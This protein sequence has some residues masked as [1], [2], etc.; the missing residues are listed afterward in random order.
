MILALSAFL[1]ATASS[2]D[3]F[4]VGLS[5]GLAKQQLSSRTNGII[6]VC[7][8][9]GA[10][11]ASSMFGAS[12]HVSASSFGWALPL[13]ASF[14]FFYLAYNERHAAAEEM[15]C[16]HVIKKKKV[17]NESRHT[18]RNHHAGTSDNSSTT[19]SPIM[20]IPMT[21]NNLVG[22]VAGGVVGIPPNIAAMCALVASYV[23]MAMGHWVGVR[24][25]STL[26]AATQ[27]PPSRLASAI[28]VILGL[29]SLW[30]AVSQKLL[31]SQ[32]KSYPGDQGSGVAG[33]A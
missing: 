10:Y 2:T 14:A 25:S 13:L 26:S 18:Q 32:G 3:N 28:Y 17:K 23:T 29:V 15:D 12:S 16:D 21:L 20:A 5:A 4:A 31:G 27:Y 30:N 1:L 9:S 8:A 7:N 22:G 11:F 24:A 6:S 33:S 19:V